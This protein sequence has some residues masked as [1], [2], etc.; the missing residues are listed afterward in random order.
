MNPV[1]RNSQP[2]A[3]R[4]PPG[5]TNHARTLPGLAVCVSSIA[6]M[7]CFVPDPLEPTG[8]RRCDI[9]FRECE[10]ALVPRRGPGDP[11]VHHADMRMGEHHD[12]P[13]KR[14]SQRT[15]TLSP[16]AFSRRLQR[17]HLLCYEHFNR[18]QVPLKKYVQDTFVRGS[19]SKI[20]DVVSASF[21][22]CE[23]RPSW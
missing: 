2:V 11:D 9:L 12:C 7:G 14:E 15:N 21:F 8:A 5:I 6:P 17:E 3:L 20:E 22:K 4:S 10:S 23:T 1:T 18:V 19:V 16:F 13:H